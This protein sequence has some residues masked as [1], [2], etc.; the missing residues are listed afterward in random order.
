MEHPRGTYY[1][2]PRR[3]SRLWAP[4]MNRVGLGV[5]IAALVFGYT[6]ADAPGPWDASLIV[7]FTLCAGWFLI[8]GALHHVPT[9]EADERWD[10][11]YDQFRTALEVFARVADHDYAHFASGHQFPYKTWR[12]HARAIPIPNPGMRPLH[13]W[14]DA[15]E[16][17]PSEDV[18]VFFRF[19]QNLLVDQQVNSFRRYAVRTY[20]RFG[21]L[22]EAK[23]DGFQE[24]MESEEVDA[25]AEE[26]VVALAYLEVAKAAQV[27]IGRGGRAR[28]G[29]WA[30][31]EYWHPDSF[32][33][34]TD[35]PEGMRPAP[36]KL[37]RTGWY[38]PQGKDPSSE[39]EG[40]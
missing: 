36:V 26:L 18:R 7:T 22:L 21:R 14:K 38:M 4:E 20:D 33:L 31:A 15:I 8:S 23:A 1:Y 13:E 11:Q 19:I 29:F 34:G 32:R 12:D 25:G 10:N 28:S 17:H 27:P 3:R 5:A 35:G 37:T 24:W 16:Q 6:V 2:V 30:L 9:A 40:G 39:S